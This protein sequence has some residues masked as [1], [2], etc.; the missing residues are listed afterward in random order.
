MVASSAWNRA[1][2]ARA[3]GIDDIT[4]YDR[5]VAAR[6]LQRCRRREAT[7]HHDVGL[8]RD[9][10]RRVFPQAFW[11]AYCPAIVDARVAAVGPTAFL[12]PLNERGHARLA[13]RVIRRKAA[14]Q[15]SDPPHALLRVRGEWPK[16][17]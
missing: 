3:D 16:V 1:R 17:R 6:L 10:F 14:K 9:H 11:V 15:D 13:F 2:K 7:G 12:Q 5:Y 8:Q 4:E